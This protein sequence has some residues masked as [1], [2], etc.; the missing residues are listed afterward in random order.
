MEYILFLTYQCNL[1]CQYC[2]AKNFVHDS[3]QNNISINDEK[4]EKICKYI[5]HD[6]YANKRENNSIVFFGGEPS[7]VPEIIL[8]IIKK[9]SRLNL[10]YFIYTNGLLLDKLPDV[11]LNKMHSILVAID[12]DK[13]CH[14]LYK[15]LGSYE[16][17]LSNVKAIKEKTNAQIIARITMEEET[18]IN[19]SV[20]NLLSHFDYV[21]W[22]IVNKP[23][24]ND[25]ERLISNYRT[26]IQALFN[27][28]M[29]NIKEGNILNIIPFNRIVYSLIT[30]EN[31]ISFRCGCGSTIQ[32]IDV[33]GNVYMCD[34]YIE[35]P[36]YAIGNINS[37]IFND[38]YFKSHYELFEDCSECKISSICMGRCRKC[39][40]TQSKDQIKTYCELTKVLVN[41]IID[42]LDDIRDIIAIKKIDLLKLRT[43]IYNTEVI[44]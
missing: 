11:L 5:E 40:E 26:N 36:T 20:T 29:K 2:F 7:L 16:K 14:E 12:G 24:F 4:V 22:Q 32:A 33:Y 17:I 23:S 3:Q 27:K 18:N 13:S 25:A 34:E 15:P 21:H 19:L 9:T 30:K 8:K 43:E 41:I 6:I 39:L 42:S 10:N 31:C 28:W 1:N 37:L 38:V 35:D 44:P